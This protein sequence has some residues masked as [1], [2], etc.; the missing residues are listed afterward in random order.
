MEELL[1][2]WI[3]DV[4]KDVLSNEYVLHKYNGIVTSLWATN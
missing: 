3:A 4:T 1:I 2:Y